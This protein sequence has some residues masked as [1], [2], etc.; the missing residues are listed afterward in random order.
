MSDLNLT[1]EAYLLGSKIFTAPKIP[2]K[3]ARKYP[4]Y[5]GGA[6][7]VSSEV[8]PLVEMAD[9]IAM[10]LRGNYPEI[11][12]DDVLEELDV[13][14]VADAFARLIEVSGIGGGGS[15]GKP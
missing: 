15:A 5:F 2:L 4:Y 6:R 10:T 9:I 11:T 7:P 3:C 12:L 13:A 14:S 8:S 1:G